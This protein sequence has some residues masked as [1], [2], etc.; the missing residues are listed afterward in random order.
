MKFDFR[1]FP[2]IPST[3]DVCR[4]FAEQGADEGLVVLADAQTAG[5]GRAGRTWYSPHGQSLYLSI[6]LRPDLHPR[7][8]GWLTMLGALAVT[9]AISQFSILN[10]RFKLKWPNDVLL[11]GKK[12]AGVLVESSFTGDRLDYAVLGIGLNVNTRFDDAP[13]D[14]RLRATSLCEALGQEVDRQ[15]VLDWLLAAF[16]VRYATLPAS[17]VADYARQLDTLGKQVRLQAGD[18]IV[19]GKAARVEDDGALVVMTTAG[20]RIVT[21]GDVVSA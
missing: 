5:R 13:E 3:M 19:E 10:S 4:A 2:T 18:E 16:S 7:R 14:V 6:L 20:E 11:N 8:I 15:A 21:F 12:V 1:R 9:D 17:P